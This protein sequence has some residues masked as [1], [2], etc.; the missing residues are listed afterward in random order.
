MTESRSADQQFLLKLRAIVEAN[1]AKE[2]FD[3]EDLASEARLS[4]STLHRRLRSMGIR[5]ASQFIRGIR[6]HKARE[7]LHNGNITASEVAYKVGFGSPAYFS[8][9]F[10]EYFGYPPGEVKKMIISGEAG[11][12]GIQAERG[13]TADSPSVSRLYMR[14]ILIIIAAIVSLA[15]I[16]VILGY[17]TSLF[18]ARDLSIVVMPFRNMSDNLENQY[19]ADGIMEDILN[20]LYHV[21]DL[22]VISRTTSEHFR[23]TD[24]TAREIARQIGAR[25]VLEGSI[26]QEGDLVRISVQLI[27]A[28]RDQHLWSEIYDRQM[29]NVLGVQGDIALQVATKL[30]AVLSESEIDRIEDLPTVNPEAYDFYMRGRFL[31]HRSINEQRTDMDKE[32]LSGSI[33]YFEKALASDSLFTLAYAGLAQAWFDISAYGW[34]P[35]KDG[36]NKARENALKA[37][38]IDPGCAEAH[39]VLGAYHG[40][41]DRQFEEA[42]K[43]LKMAIELK[44]DYPIA[45]QYYAQLLMIIGPL[46]D[47]RIFLDRALQLEPHFWILH[48]LNAYVYYFEGKHTE[49][50]MACQTA[51]DLHEGYLFNDWLFF[52]NYSKLDE[53]E[54]AKEALLGIVRNYS[55]G[56]VAVEEEIEEAYR[57]SG[58]EGLFN[59]MIERNISDPLPV[60]G[61]SGIPFFIS[62][63]YVILG[64]KENSI[65]WLEVNLEQ[66]RRRHA[67]FD[68]I[69]SNPDFD[70]LRD[71]PRFLGIV[72]R[73][74][75]TPYNYRTPTQKQYR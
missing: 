47:T 29:A 57:K 69:V 72:D 24:L 64:D 28:Q 52:L 75:L 22:R 73:I 66:P 16:L 25:N 39:T 54:K 42:R 30:N 8:K 44:P 50:I 33:R 38:D 41:G 56:G 71:D 18:R 17:N 58:I 63:W 1:L 43:E 14:K 67:F 21:S 48:N 62:W 53:G 23:D 32:G 55:D 20:N 11:C 3:V 51:L 37:I 2:E 27:D 9:C 46:E 60:F 15:V 49:A 34:F 45:N 68:L 5:N 19:F 13:T 12:N 36:F 59:W 40:W 4:R 7:L 70:I 10:H 6:L 61:L 26:R 65:H 35:V 74:G 31:L